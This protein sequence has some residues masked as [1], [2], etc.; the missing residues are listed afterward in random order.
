ML[1]IF[2]PQI[3]KQ[4]LNIKGQYKNSIFQVDF[5]QFTLNSRT[6][7]DYPNFMELKQLSPEMSRH[8]PN[9]AQQIRVKVKPLSID[10]SLHPLPL[11][12]R[13]ILWW[14]TWLI[15]FSVM[16]K[17]ASIFWEQKSFACEGNTCF[18]EDEA[19]PCPQ[20]ESVNVFLRTRRG[21]VCCPK[22][23]F[24]PLPLDWRS[25]H[26]YFLGAKRFSKW[27]FL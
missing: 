18:W 11:H 25:Y 3:W 19:V 4:L 21:C 14:S 8:S 1:N 13:H 2:V 24:L 9:V 20:G 16:C 7:E 23:S 10:P 22:C 17:K 12:P 5:W 27:W 6:W 26:R 15:H